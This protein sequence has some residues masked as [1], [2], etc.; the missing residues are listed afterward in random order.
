MALGKETDTGISQNVFNKSI[1]LNN[2]FFLKI[3]KFKSLLPGKVEDYVWSCP[4]V[5]HCVEVS[6]N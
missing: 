1:K 2:K 3:L 5:N 4:C 6:A